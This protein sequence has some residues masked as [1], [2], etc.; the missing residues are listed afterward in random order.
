MSGYAK[1]FSSILASTVWDTTPPIR[2]VWIAMLAMADRDGV[3]EASI[4]G[5][6]KMAGVERGDCERALALFL[7][8]DPD[9]RSK[10]HE[11]R[12]IREVDGGWLL[13]NY[14]KYRDKSTPDEYRKK[15]TER[16]RRWR[17]RNQKTGVTKRDKRDE[18]LL[19]R[20]V[21]EVTHS[22][23]ASAS[24]SSATSEEKIFRGAG[25]ADT[26]LTL[27][28]P[29]DQ[30][31]QPQPNSM[32]A[33]EAKSVRNRSHGLALST[34]DGI[35]N[36]PELRSAAWSAYA[37][38]YFRVKGVHPVRNAK[39]NSLIVQLCS[40]LPASDVVGVIGWYVQS[41]NA[42]YVAAGHALAPLIQDCEKLHTEYL[43]GRTGTQAAA[44]KA[45]GQ[46][47]R[48]EHNRELLEMATEMRLERE[49]RE[50]REK[51]V[52]GNGGK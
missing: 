20:E 32:R 7:A 43:T 51:A 33:R 45:D 49:A 15:A 44:R 1:L 17:E 38:A 26:A 23:A 39:S 27:S 29:P 37:G 9:S 48:Q 10:E 36:A 40:R 35:E 47:A 3:V 41:S 11:G 30:N 2:V 31:P 28:Q 6:A 16:Q 24:P 52:I 22:E 25:P 14:E 8:P 4:P 12:R 21:T 18:T 50:A 5:L 13:L 46:V 42:R 19:S 34:E